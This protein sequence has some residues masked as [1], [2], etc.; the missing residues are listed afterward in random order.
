MIGGT[1]R[2]GTAKVR[3]QARKRSQNMM[4]RALPMGRRFIL[5]EVRDEEGSDF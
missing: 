3:L 1:G 2:R 4:T 5:T